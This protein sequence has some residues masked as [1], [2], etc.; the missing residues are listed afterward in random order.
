MVPLCNYC[1]VYL[2]PL[3]IDCLLSS[4]PVVKIRQSYCGEEAQEAD[5]LVL[6]VRTY[7]RQML[8]LRLNTFSS[9]GASLWC[10]LPA[11][12]TSS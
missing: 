6:D 7:F 5:D 9:Y 3:H 1:V 11:A 8:F 10:T 12:T 2:A 4:L